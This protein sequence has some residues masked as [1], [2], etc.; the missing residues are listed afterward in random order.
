MYK[1]II[2][3]TVLVSLSCLDLTL[4]LII[5]DLLSK[6]LKVWS[7]LR[8]IIFTFRCV[9]GWKVTS[10]SL[11][12]DLD[13][14]K[15]KL[16]LTDDH[17][18][19]LFWGLDGMHDLS[20]PEQWLLLIVGSA[21]SWLQEKEASIGRQNCGKAGGNF[22]P[23]SKSSHNILWGISTHCFKLCTA[24]NWIIGVLVLWLF[25]FRKWQTVMRQRLIVKISLK[26]PPMN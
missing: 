13:D 5:F 19:S 1:L 7:K 23:R 15:E 21:A 16:C 25:I 20:I 11:G 9:S 2:G 14:F 17:K 3:G 10:E 6:T 24:E 12:L 22:I 8:V 4:L 26:S 18:Y